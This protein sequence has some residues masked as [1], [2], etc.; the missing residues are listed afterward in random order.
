MFGSTNLPY[1]AEVMAV[2]LLPNFEVLQ[3]ELYDETKDPL[4]HFDTLKAHMTLHG[5]PRK[6]ACQAFSLMLKRG[7]QTW[8]GSLLSGTIGSFDKLA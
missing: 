3:M 6:V 4:E 8:F 7:A 1:N 5:F 2:P